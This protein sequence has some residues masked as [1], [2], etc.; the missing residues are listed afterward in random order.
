[1]EFMITCTIIKSITAPV[2]NDWL[3]KTLSD[4]GVVDPDTI[5][6]IK[7]CLEFDPAKRIRKEKLLSHA[8]FR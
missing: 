7:E 2:L 8:F 6:L 4:E 5:S 1:M 3:K